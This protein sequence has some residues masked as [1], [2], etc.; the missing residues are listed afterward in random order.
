MIPIVSD[1][2]SQKEAIDKAAPTLCDYI[3]QQ[4]SSSLSPVVLCTRVVPDSVPCIQEAILEIAD[5]V[6][7]ILTTG[8]TGFGVRDVTPEVEI[9]CC[10]DLLD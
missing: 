9:A 3:H 8:G 1:R 6:H 4:A 5:T 7:V 10:C 2:V